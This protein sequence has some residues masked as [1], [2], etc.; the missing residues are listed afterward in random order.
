MHEIKR[1]ILVI[2]DEPEIGEMLHD[3]LKEH[4]F[5][6]TL[7]RDGLAARETFDKKLPGIVIVDLLLPGEHGL[8]LIRTI[9]EKYFL[10]VIIISGVYKQDEVL[11]FME[12]HF[13]EGFI[14]KPVNL[15]VLL[16]KINEII[17]GR[18][19]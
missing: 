8:N 7:V 19:L 10:P 9:K 3:F 12:E 11:D 5:T 17:K 18:R 16:Q 4:D 2:D 13:V 14:E 6:V 1:D 15:S